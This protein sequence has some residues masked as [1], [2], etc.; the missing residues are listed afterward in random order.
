MVQVVKHLTLD[1]GSGHDLVVCGFEPHVG[2]CADGVEHA[3]DLLSPCLPL[4]CSFSLSEN[5]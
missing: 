4:P 5:T 2:L 1:F 3:W